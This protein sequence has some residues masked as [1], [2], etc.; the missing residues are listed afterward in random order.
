MATGFKNS[1]IALLYLKKFRNIPLILYFYCVKEKSLVELFLT[2][3]L[4][5]KQVMS[6]V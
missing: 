6:V 4:V 1:S 2:S 3:I 5:L